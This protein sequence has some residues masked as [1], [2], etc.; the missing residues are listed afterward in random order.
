MSALANAALALAYAVGI[1]FAGA[2]V[3]LSY[4]WGA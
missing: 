3:G 2:C 1:T 4:A